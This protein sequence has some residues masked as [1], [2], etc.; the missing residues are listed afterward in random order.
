[1]MIG[2]HLNGPAPILWGRASSPGLAREERQRFSAGPRSSKRAGEE[3]DLVGIA[4]GARG[5]PGGADKF[6]FCNKIAFLGRAVQ[7]RRIKVLR[8]RRHWDASTSGDRP[9]DEVPG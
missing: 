7:A 3:D 5:A 2:W 9:I 4:A 6:N 1:M 8:D